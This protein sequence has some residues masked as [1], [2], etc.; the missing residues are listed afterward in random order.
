MNR[1]EHT[2]SVVG[3]H[4]VGLIAGLMLGASSAWAGQA[5]SAPPPRPDQ[6]AAVQ[7]PA[8]EPSGPT[9]AL[10]MDE[11]VAMALETSLGLQ[12]QRLTVN[13]AAQ[14]VASARAAFLPQ[15]NSNLTR[16]TTESPAIVFEDGTVAVSS[17]AVVSG[18]V[19][20][21]QP[22]R[23]F[24]GAVNATWDANRNTFSGTSATFNPRLGSGFRVNFTQPLW[25]DFR[26]DSARA[27]LESTERESVIVD[28]QLQQRIVAT[29]V[30]VR[31]AYLS[32]VAAIQ[33]R[34]VAQQNMDLAEQ[35]LANA[36]A[37]VAVG[38][39]PEID[40]ITAQAS[41]ESFRESLIVATARI[42]TAED[43]LRAQ[44][45]D[46]ARPD[47][48]QVRLQPTDTIELTPRTIDLDAAIQN[49]LANRLDLAVATRS[50]E[51]TDL[52]VAVARNNTRPSVDLNIGYSARGAGGTE[53][54]REGGTRVVSFGSVLG[55]A[56][57]G[58]YPS[59]STGLSVSYPLGR[60]GAE[61]ALARSEIQ[62][63]RERLDLRQLELAIIADVRQAAREVETSIR[64]VQ[65]SRAA[66]TASESQ[67]EAEER[68]FAVGL[69]DTF[70]LQQ[71]Q[72]DLASARTAELNAIIAYSNALIQFD[73]VQKIP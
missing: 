30:S 58:T 48:W 26:T 57:G 3:K 34:N 8:A 40:I 61:A 24:G 27:G 42:D 4:V 39:S 18:G 51:I 25:R 29:E 22:L 50:L 65:A 6:T 41:V 66:L 47:Y 37:R 46:P 53:F 70:Q 17:S 45:L 71:R 21:V 73:R 43:N 12:S 60:S 68:K 49:A 28:M 11:A 54:L 7:A 9:L 33:G 55:D 38:Q 62:R 10:S 64:R 36:R 1:Q 20:F 19:T 15:V 52:N 35:S 59:W 44:I 23:W 69:S 56:F 16:S 13:I 5:A 32:L 63:E 14:N 67:L 2:S 72:R 31:T